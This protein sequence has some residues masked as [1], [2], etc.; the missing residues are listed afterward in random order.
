MKAEREFRRFT[1]PPQAL[2]RAGFKGISQPSKQIYF[3]QKAP[4]VNK[5]S[6]VNI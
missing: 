6:E 4:L 1:L 5:N 3:A 2:T